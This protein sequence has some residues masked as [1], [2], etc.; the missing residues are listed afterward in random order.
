M[1]S[2]DKGS[3]EISLGRAFSFLPSISKFN[4]AEKKLSESIKFLIEFLFKLLLPYLILLVPFGILFSFRAFD[5]KSQYTKANWIF[6]LSSILFMSFI[7]SVVPEKRFLLFLMPFLVLFSVIPIHRVT[8]YGLSTFSFT[9]KQ[10]NVFL[11]IV[12]SIVI[13]LSSCFTVFGFGKPDVSFENEK[14]ENHLKVLNFHPELAVEKIMTIE[15]KKE[16]NN[17][18]LNQCTKEELEEFVKLNR[19]YKKKFNFPFIIAVSGKNKSEIL[20]NFRKRIKNDKNTEFKEAIKQ[21]KKI[22]SLRLKQI[23]NN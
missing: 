7:L 23:N 13:I 8:E 17:A 16:Q 5:Q 10:K 14:K 9:K 2:S 20:D 4:I 3:N 19:D 21:V 11:I 12:I 6:I 15:S 22:A 1:G 18:E